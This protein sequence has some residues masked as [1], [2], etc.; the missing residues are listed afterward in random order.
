MHHRL[1]QGRKNGDLTEK[2]EYPDSALTTISSRYT[3]VA[4]QDFV[5]SGVFSTA[6][7]GRIT[8][9]LWVFHTRVSGF[10]P[11]SPPSCQGVQAQ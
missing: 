3:L 10:P 7:S 2:E 8:G 5:V 4:P 1:H 6:E 9:S 11:S